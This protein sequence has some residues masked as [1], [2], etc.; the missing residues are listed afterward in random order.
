MSVAPPDSSW[1][2]S[3]LNALKDGLFTVL[4]TFYNM[5]PILGSNPISMEAAFYIV[6]F[7][8]PL[9]F[10]DYFGDG[11]IRDTIDYG[12]HGAYNTV[13]RR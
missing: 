1:I 11:I 2:G 8:G 6:A 9:L 4:T 5:I 12:I 3:V 10:I 13:R 7:I